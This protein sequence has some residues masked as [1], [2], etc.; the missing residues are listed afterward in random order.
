M[1]IEIK[2]LAPELIND[3]IDFFENIAFSDNPEWGGCYCVWYHWNDLL[4]IERKKYELAGGTCFK[5][6]LAIRYIRDGILRGY[7]AYVDG[8]VVGWCNTNDKSNYSG[9]SKEKRP[10][11]WQNTNGE[12]KVKSIVCYTIA[13]NIRG[14]GIATQLLKRVCEDAKLYG[15]DFVEAYPGAGEANVH[16]YHGPYSIYK[17]NGFSVYKDLGDEFVVRKYL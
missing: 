3:Y 4:D 13:P 2:I 8:S 10:E 14:K 9:L 15:Y 1:N 12:E 7:L 11:L 16:S 17:K 5:R 6:E